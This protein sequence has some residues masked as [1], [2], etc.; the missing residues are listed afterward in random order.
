MKHRVRDVLRLSGFM[1][2]FLAMLAL[3]GA[4]ALGQAID[5]NVVGTV[6]D[7]QGAAVVGVEITAT[8]VA[9]NVTVAAKTGVTGEYRFD[10]LL[11]GTYQ[12]ITKVTGFKS[13]SELVEVELNKTATRNITLS[14]GAASETVDG[15]EIEHFEDRHGLL[16]GPLVGRI[17]HKEPAT[18]PAAPEK[19]AS[20]A[21]SPCVHLFIC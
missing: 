12:I 2:A 7:T 5:G 19:A 13:V 15:Q 20:E 8:N 4:S 14:P 21:E 6:M 17:F 16:G 18:L 1:F 10:H 3:C 9:T 11:A